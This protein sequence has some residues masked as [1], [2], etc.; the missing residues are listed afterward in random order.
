M[1]VAGNALCACLA[2]V[3]VSNAA[4]NLVEKQGV[5]I[6]RWQ[7]ALPARM[8]RFWNGDPLRHFL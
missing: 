1:T 3:F 8:K 5:F 4:V 2:A 6:L 7:T